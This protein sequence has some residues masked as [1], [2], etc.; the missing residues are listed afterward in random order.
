MIAIGG[1]AL[2]TQAARTDVRTRAIRSGFAPAIN[3]VSVSRWE[4]LSEEA[5][6]AILWSSRNGG[7][8]AQD[9][10]TAPSCSRAGEGI[11]LKGSAA[12]LAR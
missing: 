1:G 8:H 5:A 6:H 4:R 10:S 9:C 7:F 11:K 12:E 2:M 3:A